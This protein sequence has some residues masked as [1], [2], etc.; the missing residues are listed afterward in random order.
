V[1]APSTG[2]GKGCGGKNVCLAESSLLQEPSTDVED[3][4]ARDTSVLDIAL[5]LGRRGAINH[6]TICGLLTECLQM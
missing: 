5:V 4:L 1:V 6:D 2:T 3:A